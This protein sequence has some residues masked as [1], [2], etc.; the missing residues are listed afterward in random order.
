[1]MINH[2]RGVT[3]KSIKTFL[4]LYL[5]LFIPL[6]GA[7]NLNLDDIKRGIVLTHSTFQDEF[8]V[9]VRIN[10]VEIKNNEM[11]FSIPKRSDEDPIFLSYEMHG[12]LGKYKL[13]SAHQESVTNRLPDPYNNYPA[14]YYK[15]EDKGSYCLAGL[16]QVAMYLV[17]MTNGGGGGPKKQMSS[18]KFQQDYQID[19]LADMAVNNLIPYVVSNNHY[20]SRQGIDA[21]NLGFWSIA[22]YGALNNF[23][24]EGVKEVNGF[25]QWQPKDFQPNFGSDIFFDEQVYL[26]IQKFSE[27]AKIPKSWNMDC[28]AQDVQDTL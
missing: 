11:V 27:K 23:T 12:L 3:M 26:A 20:V 13:P 16:G 15:Q 7:E 21:F 24:I 18:N 2:L 10:D 6:A 22:K 9:P 28:F 25:A 19:E 5:F 8:T 14:F 1:M 17:A 4:A